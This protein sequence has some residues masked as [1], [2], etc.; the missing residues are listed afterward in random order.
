MVSGLCLLAISGQADVMPGYQ[1]QQPY[2]YAQTGYVDSAQQNVVVE[3]SPIVAKKQKEREFCVSNSMGNTFVWA[4]NNSDTSNYSYMVEDIRDVTNNSCFVKVGMSSATGRVDLSG[5]KN[6]YFQIGQ[7][8]ICGSWV[9][10]KELEKRILDTRKSKRVWGTVAG[11]V[12]GAAVGVGTMELFGNKLIGGKVEGQKAL[13]GQELLRSQILTLKQSN[14]DEYSR[15]LKA[16]DDLETVCN[17]SEV[18]GSANKPD[19]CNP[20]NNPF[21]GLK[22]QLNN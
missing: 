22:N 14:P 1:T 6:Q 16:L 15:I 4:S 17:D 12:G 18:W 5:I 2:S 11:A 19:D 8:V 9:D 3:E 7:S 20:E 10:K 21:L 13:S